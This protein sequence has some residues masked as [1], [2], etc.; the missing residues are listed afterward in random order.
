MDL[1][2]VMVSTSAEVTAL[3]R[4]SSARIAYLDGAPHVP[5]D[6][7]EANLLPQRVDR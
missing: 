7:A 3:V 1:S 4:M 2:K 6:Q 5:Q